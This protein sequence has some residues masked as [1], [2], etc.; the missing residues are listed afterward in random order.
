MSYSVPYPDNIEY[1]Y[2]L[3]DPRDYEPFYVGRTKDP[4]TRLSA[5]IN[6]G[7]R[8]E[9]DPDGTKP[10]IISN[11]LDDGLT[12]I[13]RVIEVTTARYAPLREYEWWEALLERG[14][15]IVNVVKRTGIREFRPERIPEPE[16]EFVGIVAPPITK[17]MEV[18]DIARK[19]DM[20]ESKRKRAQIVYAL[21]AFTEDTTRWHEIKQI[22]KRYISNG[23]RR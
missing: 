4:D 5:H 12:P 15:G 13:M 22:G 23:V 3:V 11:L 7:R 2:L 17:N 21:L 8:Y 1:V 14:Y 19:L 16:D 18:A 9:P 20:I 10:A 6:D